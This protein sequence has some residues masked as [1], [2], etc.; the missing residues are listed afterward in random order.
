MSRPCTI[1]QHSMRPQIER[2]LF[3][4]TAYRQIAEQFAVSAAG[5]TRHVEHIRELLQREKKRSE[6]LHTESLRA[7]C[8]ALLRD[9]YRLRFVAEQRGSVRTALRAID[10][11]LTALTLAARLSGELT[12]QVTQQVQVNVS[13]VSPIAKMTRREMREETAR[14]DALLL[15]AGIDP[16]SDLD[17]PEVAVGT[18]NI[19]ETLTTRW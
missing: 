13:N 14:I 11:A 7:Q 18:E 16:E 8:N 10:T 15:E 19:T 2:A 5:V 12:A 1:C 3:N 6:N 4:G 17:D 9:T